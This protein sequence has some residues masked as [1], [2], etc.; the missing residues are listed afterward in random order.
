MKQKAV[1]QSAGDLIVTSRLLV[2]QTR[3]ILLSS[4]QK[5]VHAEP[6]VKTRIERLQKAAF[7][8]H[9]DYRAAVLAW[10]NPETSQF[11]MA[12]YAT[13]IEGAEDLVTKLRA[14]ANELPLSDRI[15]MESDVAQVDEIIKRWRETLVES[16]TEAVA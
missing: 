4:S 2:L 14:S 1:L 10:A 3:R 9:D 12:A 7:K 15:A 5:R 6:E 16:M 11:S 13:M 8:A